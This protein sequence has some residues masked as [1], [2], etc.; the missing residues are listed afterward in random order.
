MVVCPFVLFI[1]TIVLTVLLLL[2]DSNYSFGILN[3]LLVAVYLLSYYNYNTNS[4][5]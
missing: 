2:T 1:L 4:I 3:L 5:K